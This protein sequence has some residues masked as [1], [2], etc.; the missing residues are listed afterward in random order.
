MKIIKFTM[1]ARMYLPPPPRQLQ[2]YTDLTLIPFCVMYEA[3]LMVLLKS[4]YTITQKN[5]T[6]PP[7][8]SK[9]MTVS[10]FGTLLQKVMTLS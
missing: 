1:G 7:P 5:E 9:V 2:I 3:F 4:D 8:T 6:G 10:Q